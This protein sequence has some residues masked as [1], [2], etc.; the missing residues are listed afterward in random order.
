MKPET[1][2]L[3]RLFKVDVSDYA[4][5]SNRMECAAALEVCGTVVALKRIAPDSVHKSRDGGL[6]LN[7][8]DPE[9]AI[10]AFDRLMAR[11][12]DGA[13]VLVTPM[14]AAGIEIVIGGVR[15]RQFGLIV[16]LGLGGV[17]IEALNNVMFR[18]API[19]P[20]E[21]VDMFGKHR[22]RSLFGIGQG[23]AVPEIEAASM[24]LAKISTL[25][26]ARPEIAKIGLNPVF[27][28]EGGPAI[29]DA[30]IVLT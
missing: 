8:A 11:G 1:S 16:M 14:I 10:V 23:D 21:G 20:R 26:A 3:L 9:M 2:D 24:L 15:D 30:R 4:V 18:P 19:S 29:A 13:R 25:M 12:Q 7:I 6:A 22:S 17:G 27:L 28:R 5:A